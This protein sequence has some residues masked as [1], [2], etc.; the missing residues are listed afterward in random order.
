MK[1]YLACLISLYSLGLIGH[2]ELPTRGKLPNNH[3]VPRRACFFQQN[4]QPQ[5]C[6]FQTKENIVHHLELGRKGKQKKKEAAASFAFARFRQI[7]WE[8]LKEEKCLIYF[9]KSEW[10]VLLLPTTGRLHLPTTYFI[11]VGRQVCRKKTTRL[12]KA[13]A[14]S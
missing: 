14:Y 10:W 4:K 13:I 9:Q 2:Q 3:A 6:T 7:R 12:L 5:H 11:Q 1:A 8:N